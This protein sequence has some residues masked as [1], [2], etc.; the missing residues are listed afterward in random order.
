MTMTDELATY[1]AI[2][3]IHTHVDDWYD[4]FGN[5]IKLAE[6]VMDTEFV[7]DSMRRRPGAIAA[8]ILTGRE[9]G[10]PP[11]MALRMIYTIHGRPAQTAELMRALILR[12]GH[13]LRDVEVTNTRVIIEGRRN[14]ETEWAKATFTE[15]DARKA[16]IRLSDY[17]A[18]KLY[19]RATSRL[20]RRKFADVIAGLPSVDELEDINPELTETPDT[21]T[22]GPPIQRKR[23]TKPAKAART[24]P[25]PAP[26]TT[27][28]DNDDIAEL[29]GDTPTQEPQ[30][31]ADQNRNNMTAR[32]RQR[33][34]PDT[35]LPASPDLSGP[36]TEDQTPTFLDIIDQSGEPRAEPEPDTKPPE[37]PPTPAQNRLLHKLFREVAITDRQDRLLICGEILGIGSLTSSTDLTTSECSRI[38]DNLQQ[39]IEDSSA[40]DHISDMLNRAVQR[41]DDED[42]EQ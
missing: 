12:A 9:M 16:G 31:P 36:A 4:A 20:A 7:P 29:L 37:G 21:A 26:E 38:I 8:T 10:L 25:K 42:Q 41:M 28:T 39:W 33:H 22:G 27:R 18:D 3:P 35:I 14:G 32:K 15:A 34:D 5:I 24:Q 13:E 40:E 23:P 11:M 2:S 17:P 19:A 30:S 1:Q 6:Y